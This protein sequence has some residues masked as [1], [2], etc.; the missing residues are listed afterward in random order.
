MVYI[1]QRKLINSSHPFYTHSFSSSMHC[2]FRIIWLKA[3]KI[4]EQTKVEIKPGWQNVS[5]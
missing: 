1:S 4:D 2:Y 3:E 5:A